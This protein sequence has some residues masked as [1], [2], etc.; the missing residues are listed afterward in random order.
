M[1]VRVVAVAFV[2]MGV[3]ALSF[4]TTA[5]AAPAWPLDHEG[6]PQTVADSGYNAQE[7]GPDSFVTPEQPAFW[8]PAQP[9]P[10]LISP[11]GKASRI[12]CLGSGAVDRCWQADPSGRPHQLASVPSPLGSVVPNSPLIF[13]FQG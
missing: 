5:E 1:K 10:R 4:A 8:D 7:A 9:L 11:F 2:A 12:V 3:P 13:Y 6:W